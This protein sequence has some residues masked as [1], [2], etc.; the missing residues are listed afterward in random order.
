MTFSPFAIHF[1]FTNFSIRHFVYR[2]TVWSAF[3]LSTFCRRNKT[4]PLICHF[5]LLFYA[6]QLIGT[7]IASFT[8]ND[9]RFDVTSFVDDMSFHVIYTSCHL[10]F[11]SF[12]LHV[13][14]TSCHLYFTSFILHVI[15]TSC[16]L[17][18]TSIL[19]HVIYTS[20]QL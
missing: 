5:I 8:R 20:R 2:Q 4:H 7:S 12:I 14:H 9:D 18:F 15:Y 17:Y 3:C 19:I 1:F 6:W 16:H 10:Y 13:I 11:I